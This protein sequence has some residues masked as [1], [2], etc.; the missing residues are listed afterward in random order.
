[1]LQSAF[2]LIKTALPWTIHSESVL[3]L[4]IH[5]T[6]TTQHQRLL[7]SSQLHGALTHEGTFHSSPLGSGEQLEPRRIQG[8]HH[9]SLLGAGNGNTL[10]S[11]TRHHG[12]IVLATRHGQEFGPCCTQEVPY[13]VLLLL[14]FSVAVT[15]T[16]FLLQSPTHHLESPSIT[17][18]PI[19][20]KTGDNKLQTYLRT[21]LQLYS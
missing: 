14:P 2:Q 11:R 4:Y 5:N 1:M 18:S 12:N 8:K 19:R 17:E 6:R 10:P 3:Q 20:M 21:I 7:K 13:E 15:V 16:A 9:D